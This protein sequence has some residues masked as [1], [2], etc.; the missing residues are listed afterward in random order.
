[1]FLVSY[2]LPT[3]C[4][5]IYIVEV[6]PAKLK[7]LFGSLYW[8][9]TAIGILLV[10]TLGAIPGFLYYDL[11]LATAA[12]VIPTICCQC[13]LP[14]TPRWL[15]AHQKL[16]QAQHILRKLRGKDADIRKELKELQDNFAESGKYK[17]R[18]NIKYLLEPSARRAL[19]LSV[20]LMIFQQMT[21][22]NVVIFYAGNIL[23][24]A[25]VVNPITVAG[26]AVGGTQVL[27]V[28]IS[29]LLVDC[30][31]RKVLLVTSSIL[32]CV[33]TGLLGLYYFLTDYVCV[34]RYNV[35]PSMPQ[36]SSMTGLPLYCEPESSK[37][38]VLAIFSVVLFIIAFS[39]GW[40]TIPWVMMSELSP[41]RVRGLLS[42]IA[43]FANWT[44]ASFLTGLFPEYQGLVSNYGS[45]WTLMGITL[46]SIPFVLIF[47]PETKGKS[48]ELIE[49]QMKSRT[50]SNNIQVT[51]NL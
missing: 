22:T 41:L 24:D 1:M 40:S 27:A 16:E 10:Y 23:A 19:F 48:L 50:K 21:G 31:G 3:V 49:K 5:Q 26:Y 15:L 47:V 44:T 32:V 33:S 9:S 45:W 28:L 25:K 6:S 20:C 34:H 35:D 13:F 11:S 30:I 18:K 36:N 17:W 42:G 12:L 14:E 8:F 46:L 43:T 2:C 39:I 51:K 7:G 38:F 29:V 37:F 4:I